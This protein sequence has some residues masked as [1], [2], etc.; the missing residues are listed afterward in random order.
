MGYP[1]EYYDAFAEMEK[2]PWAWG[3]API[4]HGCFEN[5]W[6]GAVEAAAR[7]IEQGGGAAEIRALAVYT[8]QSACP[9]GCGCVT[10]DDPDA[11]ECACDGPCTM[12]P[13]WPYATPAD[14]TD[15]RGEAGDGAATTDDPAPLGSAERGRQL[16]SER[17]SLIAQG[18]DPS[19]L[20]VPLHPGT[21]TRTD[22]RA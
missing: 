8:D 16:A 12:D 9:S 6:A 17:E 5:G 4:H 19:Q 13:A 2:E 21:P 20:V 22:P 7:L 3:L 14:P 1:Q 10:E 15:R 18:A 11:R